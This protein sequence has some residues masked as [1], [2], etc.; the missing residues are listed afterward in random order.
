MADR[1]AFRTDIATRVGMCREDRS[2]TRAGLLAESSSGRRNRFGG[3]RKRT[4][5]GKSRKGFV[6]ILKAIPR[7]TKVQ[8]E[9]PRKVSTA[10]KILL[11]VLSCHKPMLALRLH[12]TAPQLPVITPRLLSRHPAR[13]SSPVPSCVVNLASQAASSATTMPSS[14]S[15][16]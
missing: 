2:G 9:Y 12:R 11:L 6:V 5:L 15:Y 10:C 14:I 8:L 4:G 1:C 7:N 16:L 3:R 13:L